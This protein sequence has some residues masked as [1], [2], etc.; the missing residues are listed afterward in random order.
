[1]I[2]YHMIQKPKWAQILA[3]RATNLNKKNVAGSTYRH[4]DIWSHSI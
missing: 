1:M 3:Q 2:K 4:V